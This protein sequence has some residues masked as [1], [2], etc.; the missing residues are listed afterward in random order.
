MS[1]DLKQFMEN[2]PVQCTTSL[3][4]IA[5]PYS[6]PDPLTM[7]QRVADVASCVDAI[8]AN[9]E[10]VTPKSPILETVDMKDRGVIPKEGWYKYDFG[11][12]NKADRLI[13]LMLDG[14]E[15]SIGVGLEIAFALGKGIPI[16]YYT[17]DDIHVNRYPLKM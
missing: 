1:K 14:W 5:S 2:K 11:L 4:Y 7:S 10:N 13:V 16:S 15:S 8:A 12:L 17:L 6:H 3:W 9:Y